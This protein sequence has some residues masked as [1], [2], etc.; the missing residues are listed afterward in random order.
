MFE[1]SWFISFEIQVQLQLLAHTWATL[2]QLSRSPNLI[3]YYEVLFQLLTYLLVHL[4]FH[5]LLDPAH[6]SLK[7][8]NWYIISPPE[9]F[10]YKMI[11]V[12][13]VWVLPDLQAAHLSPAPD[14]EAGG[15]GGGETHVYTAGVELCPPPPHRPAGHPGLRPLPPPLAPGVHLSRQPERY[16]VIWTK[17][18]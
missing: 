8:I 17:P 14:G 10:T 11:V 3:H 5:V 6:S 15:V 2:S 4:L 12:L 9:I 16:S 7:R 18:T 1:R 13:A